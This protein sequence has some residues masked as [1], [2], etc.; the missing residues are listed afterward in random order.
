LWVARPR[1]DTAVTLRLNG[2]LTWDAELV[3]AV[4][5]SGQPGL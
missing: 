2:S 3:E 5:Q 1:V 4:F